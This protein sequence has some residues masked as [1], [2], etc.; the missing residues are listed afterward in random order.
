MLNKNNIEPLAFPPLNP[1]TS[2]SILCRH[3]INR[4]PNTPK[5]RDALCSETY[6]AGSIAGRKKDQT[7]PNDA[8][9]ASCPNVPSN[10]PGI[11]NKLL[12]K[13]GEEDSPCTRKDSLKNAPSQEK[14]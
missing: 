9:R 2:E 11:C 6:F 13:S 1:T 4:S 3:F 14:S 8:E 10:L 7:S 12:G 5:C